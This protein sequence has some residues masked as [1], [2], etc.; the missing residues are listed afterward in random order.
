MSCF[1]YD[2]SLGKYTPTA[3]GIMRIGG[4]LSM[5]GIAIFSLIMW[6]RELKR[7]ISPDV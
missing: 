1:S 6:R 4:V 2:T 3:F 7:K 5:I